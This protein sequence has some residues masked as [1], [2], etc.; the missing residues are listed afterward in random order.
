[1]IVVFF[2][3]GAVFVVYHIKQYSLNQ[4][5]AKSMII[6]FVSVFAILL[7]INIVLF[8]LVPWSEY[9]GE[10]LYFGKDTIMLMARAL[11]Y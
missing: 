3:V 5:G 9:V 11:S 10:D 6:T 4:A 7:L 1:M 2:V 8:V